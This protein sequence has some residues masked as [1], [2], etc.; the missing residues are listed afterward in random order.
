MRKAQSTIEFAGTT[1]LFISLLG[2]LLASGVDV[3]P[4]F[5]SDIE[6]T[7]LHIEAERVTTEMLTNPGYNIEGNSNWHLDD[8]EL[9]AFGLADQSFRINN[10]KLNSIDT[11]AEEDDEVSYNDFR[12]LVDAS[13][14]YRFNFIWFPIVQSN[15]NFEK[16]SPPDEITEPIHDSYDEMDDVI[17]YGST[18]LR[19]SRANFLVGAQD[20]SYNTLYF[21]EG[22]WNFLSS[23]PHRV[24][25]ELM[26]GNDVYEIESFQNREDKPG[27]ML[28]LRKDVTEFGAQIDRSDSVYRLE[29][30]AV[31][32]DDSSHDHPIR[33]EV[34]VW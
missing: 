21:S 26:I 2:V 30:Y 20:G 4:Q 19:G 16:E 29:R 10:E 9:V 1:L 27:T 33:L 15:D 13:N 17:Y 32:D 23:D 5:N 22:N 34:F 8:E 6:T 14:Q 28:V 25:E 3:V 12:S 7:E 11:L 31:L 24:N 18:R